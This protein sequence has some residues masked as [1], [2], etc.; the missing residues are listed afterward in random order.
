LV[1][2]GAYP[3][4]FAAKIIYRVYLPLLE[5]VPNAQRE[6]SNEQ[7]DHAQRHPSSQN[8]REISPCIEGEVRH[9]DRTLYISGVPAN[10][11]IVPRVASAHAATGIRTPHAAGDS[12]GSIFAGIPGSEVA[13]RPLRRRR[14]GINN[15]AD[16]VPHDRLPIV[17]VVCHK[18]HSALIQRNV[19]VENV[20]CIDD[21]IAPLDAGHRDERIDLSSSLEIEHRFLV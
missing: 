20:A 14:D 1:A 3:S 7:T 9:V 5:P 21:V 8:H 6:L 11:A 18:V 13:A 10:L 2:T 17:A 4:S 12:I 16:I 15:E 19:L